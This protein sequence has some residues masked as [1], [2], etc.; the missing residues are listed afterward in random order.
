MSD[1]WNKL[2][3][4]GHAGEREYWWRECIVPRPTMYPKLWMDRHIHVHGEQI[5]YNMH[6]CSRATSDKPKKV[7]TQSSGPFCSVSCVQ[8]THVC[9]VGVVVGADQ[10]D[11]VL[12]VRV[13]VPAGQHA[14]QVHSFLL[15]KR[16]TR[17][18]SRGTY[19][20]I[21][22]FSSCAVLEIGFRESW[23][24]HQFTLIVWATAW[25]NN[26]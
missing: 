19:G 4:C 3:I 26:S 14:N 20:W 5:Y 1:L 25:T 9:D 11:V 8:L 10:Q 13:P 17:L 22:L 18:S 7:T 6:G 21:S 23:R 12:H 16:N 24:R 2:I 15:G